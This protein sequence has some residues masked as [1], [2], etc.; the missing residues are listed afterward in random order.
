MI[1]QDKYVRPRI[2]L[3]HAIS[4]R[5]LMQKI[6]VQGLMSG[7]LSNDDRTNIQLFELKLTEL[8]T[9]AETRQAIRDLR[10]S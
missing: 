8:I 7:E 2:E 5:D 6:V 3:D 9:L 10:S 4:L 1:Q